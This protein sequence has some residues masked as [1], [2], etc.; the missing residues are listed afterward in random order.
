MDPHSNAAISAAA[1]DTHGGLPDRQRRI[2]FFSISVGVV[3]GVFDA[4][5]LFVALPTLAEQFGVSASQSIWVILSYQ[6][7]M[8]A[9]LLPFSALGDAVGHRRLQLGGLIVVA[10][11]SALATFTDS[12]VLLC[13]AR[14]LQGFGAAASMAIHGAVLRDIYPARSFG[15]GVGA[16]TL[17]V[18]VTGAATP[19]LAAA[20]L[21]NWDWQWL[22][23]VNVPAAALA[24]IAGFVA[25]PSVARRPTRLDGLSVGLNV[26]AFGLLIAGIGSIGRGSSVVVTLEIALGAAAAAALTFRQL[27]VPAPMLP[28]DLFHLKPFASS[29]GAAVLAFAAQ[30]MMFVALPFYL[31]STLGRSV[32]ETGILLT[33]WPVATAL[34]SVNVGRLTERFEPAVLC[35]LGMAIYAA[36]GLGFVLGSDGMP[37]WQ[38]IATLALCGLGFGLFQAP[39][40]K[41]MLLSVPRARTSGASGAQATSRLVGQSLGAGCVAGIYALGDLAAT[42]GVLGISIA[43]ALAAGVAVL[44]PIAVSTKD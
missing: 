38:L 1:V 5:A 12:F 16:T 31:Q 9:S 10:A 36:A 42:S 26:L 30:T 40:N 28:V 27:R 20:I 17:V 32:A 23:W 8:V 2:A 6:I 19:S 14:A 29:V 11:A 34:V 7:A 21:S 18:A 13:S 25:M 15:H 39:N 24:Y 37:L 33:P 4:A 22:F 44:L 43:L 3:I 41:V 35:A